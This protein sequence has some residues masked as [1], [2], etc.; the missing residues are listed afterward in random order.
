[1]IDPRSIQSF[2]DEM[3]KIGANPFK[4]IGGGF[5]QLGRLASNVGK[6][7]KKVVASNIATREPI[8]RGLIGGL[9][10]EAGKLR[11][12]VQKSWERGYQGTGGWWGGAKNVAKTHGAMATAAGGTALAG[13]GGY[14]VVKGEPKNP[15][16]GRPR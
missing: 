3:T 8:Q 9:K 15:Q 14:K 4:F 13:Y 2:S 10:R 11:E 12:G 5:Q 1:M 16:Y 7:A 6:S